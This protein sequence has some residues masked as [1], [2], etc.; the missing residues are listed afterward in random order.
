[1]DPPHMSRI[2]VQSLQPSPHGS[3]QCGGEQPLLETNG[4]RRA[5]LSERQRW[6]GP[7]SPLFLSV[8]DRDWARA[9]LE[10]IHGGHEQ[11]VTTPDCNGV[12]APGE[13]VMAH[14]AEQTPT[15]THAQNRAEQ[16]TLT[17]D[18]TRSVWVRGAVASNRNA[19]ETIPRN[20]YADAHLACLL[21]DAAFDASSSIEEPMC[22]VES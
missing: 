7:L 5:C 20:I 12:D 4:G 1:M 9:A 16:I 17:N 8:G 2:S 3:K 11:H 19:A 22:C 18:L 14:I 15:Y 10:G 13:K 6:Q 21:C